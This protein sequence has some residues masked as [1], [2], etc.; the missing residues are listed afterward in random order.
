MRTEPPAASLIAP[1]LERMPLSDLTALARRK[2]DTPWLELALR[3]GRAVEDRGIV[4]LVAD[5]ADSEIWPARVFIAEH[6]GERHA[7]FVTY[8]YPDGK[9]LEVLTQTDDTIRDSQAG[10][11][12]RAALLSR[13]GEPGSVSQASGAAGGRGKRRSAG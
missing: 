1:A 12:G 6:L 2:A 13:R 4:W 9:D 8:A 3:S 5:E 7:V 11:P 10:E